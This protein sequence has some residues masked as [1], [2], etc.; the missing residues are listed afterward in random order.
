MRQ[1]LDDSMKKNFIIFNSGKSNKLFRAVTFALVLIS[2]S[3]NYPATFLF[4]K[5]KYAQAPNQTTKN[6]N[7]TPL[8]SQEPMLLNY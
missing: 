1:R 3:L 7:S 2:S 5:I 6:Q 4:P 8:G